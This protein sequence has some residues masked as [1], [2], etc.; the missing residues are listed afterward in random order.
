MKKIII[1]LLALLMSAC[2]A[3]KP[4]ETLSSMQ[5]EP[6]AETAVMETTV[7]PPT[8]QKAPIETVEEDTPTELSKNV[9]TLPESDI[10][11][12]KAEKMNE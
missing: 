11:L 12:Q 2:S 5:T 10:V 1:L 4:L 7:E 8:T 3:K 6:T 9:K